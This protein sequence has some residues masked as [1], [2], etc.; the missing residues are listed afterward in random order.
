MSKV[1]RKVEHAQL[2]TW[3]LYSLTLHSVS[4]GR[5]Q[6]PEPK[7]DVLMTVLNRQGE[8]WASR[9]Q[10]TQQSWLWVLGMHVL[11]PSSF[12]FFSVETVRDVALAKTSFKLLVL[13]LLSQD[14]IV[15]DV[16]CYFCVWLTSLWVVVVMVTQASLCSQ[17]EHLPCWV[18]L[19]QKAHKESL[20]YI[21]VYF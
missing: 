8:G 19:T 4:L 1:V 7:G 2:I 15:T 9:P 14:C 5:H 11:L 21:Q 20:H 12:P 17:R 16:C 6:L 13:L 3:L 18:M 10:E